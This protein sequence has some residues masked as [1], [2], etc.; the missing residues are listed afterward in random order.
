M[1]RA[2]YPTHIAGAGDLQPTDIGLP[3][4]LHSDVPLDRCLDLL[5]R[6]TRLVQIYSAGWRSLL[7]PHARRAARASG[8]RLTVHGPSGADPD[9]GS[10]VER[11]RLRA[12]DVH[13]SHIEAAGEAGALC[14]VVHP[15]SSPGCCELSSEAHEALRRSLLELEQVQQL[16]GVRIAVENMP[17]RGGVGVARAPRGRRYPERGVCDATAAST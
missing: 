6:R 4:Q 13:R 11:Q 5:A 17:S 14:Y 9:L 15:D 2:P 7:V 10:T 1:V 8:L 3:S 12:V 16:T